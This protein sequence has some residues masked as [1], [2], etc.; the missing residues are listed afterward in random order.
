[1]A[2]QDT[3]AHTGAYL[4]HAS[5]VCLACQRAPEGRGLLESPVSDVTP[6]RPTGTNRKFLAWNSPGE[7]WKM[8]AGLAVWRR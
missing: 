5:Q 4:L 8:P 1:M 2:R 3:L 6:A 7:C